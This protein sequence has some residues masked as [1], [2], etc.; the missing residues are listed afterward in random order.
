MDT[1]KKYIISGHSTIQSTNKLYT[2]PKNTYLLPLAQCG[3][4][5]TI[6]HNKMYSK[7]FQN[8]NTLN[9]FIRNHPGGVFKTGNTI[10]NVTVSMKPVMGVINKFVHGVMQLPLPRGANLS[11]KNTSASYKFVNQNYKN[12]K[13]SE[14]LSKHGPGVYIGD[15]CRIV[16]NLRIHSKN[17]LLAVSNNKMIPFK[18]R[19]LTSALLALQSGRYK[20][21]ATALLNAL[22]YE[23][24]RLGPTV[25][26]PTKNKIK[27]FLSR[28][29]KEQKTRK[30]KALQNNLNFFNTL[31]LT[32]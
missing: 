5:A 11:N 20:D 10:Q 7:I 17:K 30:R 29:Q 15:F 21:P 31:N 19:P 24:Q 18:N 28:L 23:R 25:N 14:I 22:R 16:P 2:I 1:K 26:L 8:K 12:K 6:A 3:R 4:P 32:Y 13:L 27:E 9:T